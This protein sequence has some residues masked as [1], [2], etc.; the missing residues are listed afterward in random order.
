MADNIPVSFIVG[1]KPQFI[2]DRQSGIS[3]IGNNIVLFIR[4]LGNLWWMIQTSVP[5]GVFDFIVIWVSDK[6]RI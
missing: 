2:K 4:S 6:P 5:D 3:T 1:L